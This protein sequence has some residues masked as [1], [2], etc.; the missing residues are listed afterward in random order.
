MARLPE[1]Y[2]WLISEFGNVMQAHHQL[3][4]E[5]KNSGPLDEKTIQLIQLAGAATSRSQGAVQSHA[6]R[7]RAAGATAAEI[8]HTLLLLTSTVGFP[9][10]AAAL[11][12]VKESLENE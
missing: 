4:K 11:S 7:A 9:T 12:W 2:N 6:K 1:N 5:L 3:G 10:I 8:Y